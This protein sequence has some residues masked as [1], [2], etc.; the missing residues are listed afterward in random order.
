MK[1][2]V[3]KLHVNKKHPQEKTT[4][5]ADY[6]S[7]SLTAIWRHTAKLLVSSC[8]LFPEIIIWYIS[9]NTKWS[10][11]VK[12][13]YQMDFITNDLSLISPS[14]F[15]FILRGYYD[16]FF[17]ICVDVFLLHLF[18]IVLVGLAYFSNHS[19]FFEGAHFWKF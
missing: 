7:L 10:K 11:H 8:A 17:Y 9:F 13:L 12:L 4:L 6:Q 15:P 19:L 18:I 3:S 16:L 5:F 1:Y 14:V 2:L